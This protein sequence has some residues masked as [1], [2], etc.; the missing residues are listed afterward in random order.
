MFQ[1]KEHDV[2]FDIIIGPNSVIKGDLESE[3]SIRIDGK[4]KGNVTSLGNVIV[5][6]SAYVSGNII[7]ANAEI[8]GNCQGDVRVQGKINL[9]HNASLQGDVVAKSFSTLEG[10]KYSGNCSVDANLDLPIKIDLSGFNE[11]DS[12]LLNFS[13]SNKESIVPDKQEHKEKEHKNAK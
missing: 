3:G 5:S 10:A 12:N 1:K 4:I 13:K 11:M 7:C 6:E 2:N 9:H 8:Y